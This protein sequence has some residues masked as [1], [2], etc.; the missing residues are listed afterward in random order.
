MAEEEIEAKD[1]KSRPAK[2]D[3]VQYNPFDMDSPYPRHA[4][5]NRDM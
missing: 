4:H 1:E 5:R 2:H 3:F